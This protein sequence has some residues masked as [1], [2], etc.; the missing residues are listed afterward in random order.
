M[1]IDQFD[2][3]AYINYYP[4]A[5]SDVNSLESAWNHWVHRGVYENRRSFIKHKYVES[6]N[7]IHNNFNILQASESNI[8]I[9]LTT[10]PSRFIE[11]D[12][13]KVIENLY[14]QKL[15]SKY[16]IINLCDNYKKQSHT[17]INIYH[18]AKKLKA[19][20][21]NLI[22]NHTVDYGPITKIMG[23]V[24]LNNKIMD[25]DI[26]IFV[27]DD[28]LY[29]SHMNIIYGLCFQLYQSDCV[30]VA[31]K[32][33]E[34]DNR[35]FFYDNY[36]DFINSSLTYAFKYKYVNELFDFFNE[37]LKIDSNIRKYYDLIVFLFY[38]T[39]KLYACGI[40]Q[41][42]HIDEIL[43]LSKI[44][45]FGE[46]ENSE[47]KKIITEKF[48]F[49]YDIFTPLYN[50]KNILDNNI[51]IPKNIDKR[52][53]L[54]NTNNVSYEPNENNF[55][56]M[57][58]DIKY[59]NKNH[60]I[61]TL[62][63]FENN[64]NDNFTITLQVNSYYM[65][66]QI[67]NNKFSRKSSFMVYFNTNISRIEHENC[68]INIVQS[69]STNNIS[70]N[71]F[72]SIVTILNYIPNLNYVL[73]DNHDVFNYLNTIDPAL[74]NIILKIRPGAYRCDL[75]RIVYLYFNEGIYIDCKMLLLSGIEYLLR[76]NNFVDDCMNGDIYNGMM[77]VREKKMLILK[78]LILDM[79][80][81]IKGEKYSD[82]FLGITGPN[83]CGKHISYNNKLILIE[84]LPW[85]NYIINRE[86][87]KK[88]VKTIYLN[89]YKEQS[90]PSYAHV[91][92]ER[93]VFNDDV[94][95]DHLLDYNK[96]F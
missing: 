4:G 6:P 94:V 47:D 5:I 43:N 75:F 26:V 81:M 87:G 60:I 15:K 44:D 93:N 9:S 45:P 95:V 11:K 90:H 57:H 22:I 35:F 89:Y 70:I 36:Q 41:Y 63:Q 78:N 74:T 33:T 32:I 13:Y 51:I 72:L 77:I 37:N 46:D 50:N 65:I 24:S 92:H 83:I 66:L 79:I 28:Q 61:V 16:I 88:I 7:L 67:P 52:Y 8:I 53:L 55:H 58:I 54:F 85:E 27:N 10:I 29:N 91:W 62:T 82:T 56:K 12:F 38:R 69:S 1:D 25:N 84:Q 71:K 30:F 68:A 96:L 39:K 86:N 80:D 49:I 76:E 3:E 42:L 17:T 21:P 31:N 48:L 64:S 14:N 20:F 73:F 34:I 19:M 2:W 23:I 18:M 59:L 40:N